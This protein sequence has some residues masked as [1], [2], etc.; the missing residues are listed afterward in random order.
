[1]TY[2]DGVVA[3]DGLRLS[4]WFVTSHCHSVSGPFLLGT[5]IIY[6]RNDPTGP[7][8]NT[9]AMANPTTLPDDSLVQSAKDARRLIAR[10][11]SALDAL[12]LREEKES[13]R[14]CETSDGENTW[15]A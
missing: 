6:K 9:N 13:R 14:H 4:D 3:I 8:H 1:M 10:K 5:S 15:K 12:G 7:E 11:N 2:S